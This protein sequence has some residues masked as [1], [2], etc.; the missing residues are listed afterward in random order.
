MPERPGIFAGLMPRMGEPGSRSTLLHGE[1]NTRIPDRPRLSYLDLTRFGQLRWL[2]TLG[3]ILISLGGLGAGALPVVDNP[4]ARLPFGQLMS[5][6]LQT[7][8]VIVLVGVGLLVLAWVLMAPYVGASREKN[9]TGAPLIAL[10]TLRRTWVAWVIPIVITAPLFTQDI[11]SYL[12]QGAIVSYGLD[13]YSAGPVQILGPEHH[14]ARSVPFIWANSPSPYG[15]IALGIAAV[16]NIATGES[17][18]FGVLAHRIV[19]VL[20]LIAAGWAVTKLA[21][22]CDVRSQ[23]AVWLGI[24][25]PLAI[26]H[27][28]GGIH[29]ESIMLGL[30]LVGME[31]GLRGVD[32]IRDARITR[33]SALSCGQPNDSAGGC[34]VKHS[35]G[36][37]SGS[38]SSSVTSSSVISSS[39]TTSTTPPSHLSSFAYRGWELIIASG[40]LISMAGMVKVT[41]FIGLGFVGMALARMTYRTQEEQLKNDTRATTDAAVSA[42]KLSQLERERPNNRWSLN[43][44]FH[45]IRAIAIQVTALV[46]T[47]VV[48]GALTGIGF[49]WVTGQGGAATIRS[50]MSITTDLGVIS[51]W[52]G[53]LLGLGDHTE[54][55]LVIT[56]GIGITISLAFMVRMLIATFRGTINPVGGCG[57]STFLLVVLFPVVHPWY[58]LWAILPLAAWA[59][60]NLFRYA[61]IGYSS[62]MC[63]F[64]LP[65]G[66]ALPPGTILSIYVASLL[67]FLTVIVALL[68]ARNKLYGPRV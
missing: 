50:W 11:Y 54:M 44:W 68:V 51:G 36:D 52:A 20:G 33:M 28:I 61:A 18:F 29:N 39:A 32:A 46:L 62:V 38:A 17:I 42:K 2:G 5:R 55:I 31:L 64:V 34:A 41:G 12:A 49:G 35:Q 60:Q 3:T 23:T 59:N 24:L 27:L 6:M 67:A 26:L 16:I 40:V 48:V 1:G 43:H 15:P 4:Y 13:P 21:R 22:R 9:I 25:N 19:S 10:S 65:R 57:V 58:M 63:F 47:A 14:L 37:T 66:L 7:S 30:S 45:I 8:S 53:M 56:R